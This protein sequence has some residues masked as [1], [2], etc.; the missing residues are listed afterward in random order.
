M[1]LFPNTLFDLFT[2]SAERYIPLTSPGIK[3]K[4]EKVKGCRHHIKSKKTSNAVHLP[5]YWN[6]LRFFLYNY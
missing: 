6:V 5:L 2:L 4:G 1:D 3:V